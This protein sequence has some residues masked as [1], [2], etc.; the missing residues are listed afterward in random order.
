MLA[1]FGRL[2][3]CQ[4][5]LM[6]LPIHH[7]S[8]LPLPVWAIKLIERRCR[9]FVWKGEHQISEGHC[10]LP[11]A[12]LCRPKEFGGLG[13]LN[14]RSFGLALRCR[15]LWKNWDKEE[16]PWSF[17]PDKAEKE[18]VAM[19]NAAC[20]I[21]LGSGHDARFWVDNWLPGGRSIAYTVQTLYSYVKDKGM[22]IRE[23]LPNNAWVRD[24]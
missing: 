7:M 9:S 12:M 17:F 4:S 13:V 15:W 14:L 2:T 6:A 18:V 20:K 23:A 21:K 1:I 19:F 11:W 8:V 24:I 5:V 16:R 22:S 10:L 3:L